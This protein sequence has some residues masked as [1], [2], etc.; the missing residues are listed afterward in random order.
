MYLLGIDLGTSFIKTSIVDTETKKA[1]ASVN[2]P[3]RGDA[4]PSIA[5]QLGGARSQ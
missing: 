2:L 4:D 5:Y 1:I 3:R